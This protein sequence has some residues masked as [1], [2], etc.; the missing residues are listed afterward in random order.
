MFELS[1]NTCSY[2]EGTLKYLVLL[3][4]GQVAAPKPPFSNMKLLIN[5]DLSK[6]ENTSKIDLYD[7]TDAIFALSGMFLN[8]ATPLP[9]CSVHCRFA[10]GPNSRQNVEPPK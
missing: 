5:L 3:R 8:N 4:V 9:A 1:K 6:Y 10:C 7:I 2:W